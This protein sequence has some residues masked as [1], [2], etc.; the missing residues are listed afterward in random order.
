[1]NIGFALSPAR[2][3]EERDLGTYASSF[4]PLLNRFIIAPQLERI[5]DYRKERLA[6]GPGQPSA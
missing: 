1:M 3:P 2:G 6:H 4:R 5:F